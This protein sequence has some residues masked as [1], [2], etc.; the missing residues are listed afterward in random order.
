MDLCWYSLG[1]S[2]SQ[3]LPTFATAGFKDAESV[4][5]NPAHS[6]TT[7]RSFPSTPLSGAS[8][9]PSPDYFVNS[10]TSPQ[11][12]KRLKKDNKEN[13]GASSTHHPAT[14]GTIAKHLPN[15]HSGSEDCSDEHSWTNP[16]NLE[17]NPF[18]RLTE[19][20]A[21]VYR[22]TK[23]ESVTKDTDLVGVRDLSDWL[24]LNW[25]TRIQ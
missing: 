6:G 20:S 12:P 5:I 22:S 17:R 16:P 11:S 10:D 3:A 8:K 7:G 15:I 14:R 4:S 23:N 21:S 25:C 1:N 13:V 18:A 2:Y 24:Q 9:R 19:K